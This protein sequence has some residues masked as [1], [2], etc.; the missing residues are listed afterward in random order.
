MIKNNRIRLCTKKLDDAT[1]DYTWKTDPEL[2]RL[3][4]AMPLDMTFNEY[5]FMYISE[6]G[7]ST[8]VKHE[9]S[10]ETLNG[11]HIGNCAY[12][13]INKFKGETEVGIILGNRQYWDKGYGTESMISLLDYIFNKHNFKRVH[14][15]T[16]DYNIRAQNCF[17]KCGFTVCGSKILN[18]YSFI[19]MELPREKWT[20]LMP[21]LSYS[22]RE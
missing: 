17:K 2:A 4:A 13:N 15:K 3:D 16:L 7:M 10:I 11:E 14:L 1:N 20:S 18:G 19:L 21:E 12:Y 8:T 6:L 22:P 9:F 5:L